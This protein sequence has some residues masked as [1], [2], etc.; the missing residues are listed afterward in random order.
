MFEKIGP[1]RV[2]SSWGFEVSVRSRATQIYV[3]Y[4]AG[5][6]VIRFDNTMNALG[7]PGFTF[8]PKHITHW[9]PPFESELLGPEKR[10]LVIENMA[11]ALD[12]LG[13]TSDALD[14]QAKVIGVFGSKGWVWK[15]EK[16]LSE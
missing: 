14:E 11:A 16:W 3:E 10:K 1:N 7:Y 5:D 12:F 4:R 9:A 15:D 13:V 8:R 6:H 2:R